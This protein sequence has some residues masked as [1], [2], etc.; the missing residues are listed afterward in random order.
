MPFQVHD[1]PFLSA[2]FVEFIAAFIT[3]LIAFAVMVALGR[4]WAR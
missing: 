4:W 3:M 2:D 1:V